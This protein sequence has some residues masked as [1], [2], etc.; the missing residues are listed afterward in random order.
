MTSDVD[1][2]T[3]LNNKIVNISLI[4]SINKFSPIIKL[5]HAH[6]FYLQHL[7]ILLGKIHH[8]Q[9]YLSAFCFYF[10]FRM[11]NNF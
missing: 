6:K 10:F 1:K 11:S 2:I 9:K 7:F 4:F 3:I 5:V 8:N